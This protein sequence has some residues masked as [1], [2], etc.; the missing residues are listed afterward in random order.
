RRKT[1]PLTSFP[2][3]AWERRLAEAEAQRG[4]ADRHR[5]LAALR[6][7][8]FPRRSL[9]TSLGLL[10][11]RFPILLRQSANHHRPPIGPALDAQAS[12]DQAG[13]VLHDLQAAAFRLPIRP[14][15]DAIA[16]IV[17]RKRQLMIVRIKADGDLFRMA[18]LD[19]IGHRFLSDVKE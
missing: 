17:Y 16:I 7:P 4:R 3:S 15:P 14:L 10:L 1:Q 8:S 5:R 12:G 18:V 13:T 11:L 9:G 2:G 19:C 6:P